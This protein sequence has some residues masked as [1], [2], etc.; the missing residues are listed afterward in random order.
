MKPQTT[1]RLDGKN[2]ELMLK[3]Y[4]DLEDH[5]DIQKVYANFDIDESIMMKMSEGS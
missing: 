2:A 1:I 4:E 5:D 3:L